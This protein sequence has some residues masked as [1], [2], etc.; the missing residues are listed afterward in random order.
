[1]LSLMS[2]LFFSVVQA[3]SVAP[4]IWQAESS[5][6]VSGVSLPESKAEECLSADQ[7][8]N[9]KASIS[10]ELSK[11]GCAV[12]KWVNKGQ[13]TDIALT[14]DKS[15]LLAKGNLRGVIADKNYNLTGSAQ[16]SFHQIP[17]EAVISLKGKWVK[18]CQK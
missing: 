1:M 2:F 18:A 12:T 13:Q 5:F 7:A 17:A 11:Q 3:Q 15:G 14:C 9:L 6:T 10:K 8:K 4:G 16:G